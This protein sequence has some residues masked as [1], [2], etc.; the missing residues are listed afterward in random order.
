MRIGLNLLQARPEIG[1][2]WNYIGRIIDVLTFYGG[3]NEYFAYC[4]PMSLPLLSRNGNVAVRTALKVGSGQIKR[5]LYE[6]SW[7]ECAARKDRLDVMHW[8]GNTKAISSRIPAA[9]TV[10]DL[11]S[12]E[13]LTTYPPARMLYARAMIPWSVKRAAVLFP[14]SQTTSLAL[15][16]RFGIGPGKV[17]VIY[18]PLGPEWRR[19]CSEEIDSF[20][21]KY[22][23]PA[24]FWLYV[25]HCYPHKNHRTLF[26]AYA[27]L[28]AADSTTWPLVLRG[29]DKPGGVNLNE[30]AQT[31]GIGGHIIRL[32]ML[33]LDEM[34][35]LYSAATA[36]IF[37]SQFEGLGI[38][39]LEALACGCPALA[40]AIPTTRELAGDNVIQ[41][42]PRDAE[43]F[44]RGMKRFQGDSSVLAEY[45]KRGM[46]C[47]RKF[48]AHSVFQAIQEGYRAACLTRPQD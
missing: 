15:R 12:F 7:L 9:I 26:Q 22:G 45:S 33:E 6:H 14:I 1:G 39:L 5:I 17:F 18:Y 36:L 21:V 37:P 10:Y 34:T 35:L 11:R 38:P 48:S 47:A 23:L 31:F 42:D 8:F 43:A 20:R 30:L 13:N 4:S 29:D 40:S 44:E 16:Q 28:I 46:E 25:A 2:G 41:C 27:R 19:R 3:G 32:P 24:K